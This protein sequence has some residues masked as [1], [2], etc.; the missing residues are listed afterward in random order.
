MRWP[1]WSFSLGEARVMGRAR[2]VPRTWCG[3]A[4]ARKRDRVLIYACVAGAELRA[5]CRTVCRSI[6]CSTAGCSHSLSLSAVLYQR[7]ARASEAGDQTHRDHLEPGA[8]AMKVTPR[9]SS[10]SQP[11][12]RGDS[13][14]SLE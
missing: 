10:S 11:P 1:A 6:C 9:S 14:G 7:E 12:P 2:E 8:E 4:G 3:R 5:R 13:D